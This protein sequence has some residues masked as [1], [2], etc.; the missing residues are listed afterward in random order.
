ERQRDTEGD[1]RQDDPRAQLIE[2]VDDRQSIVVSHR[3]YSTGHRVAPGFRLA[4]RLPAAR[5]FGLGGLLRLRRRRGRRGRRGGGLLLGRGR[6][7]GRSG[8][9]AGR[10]RLVGRR[11]LLVVVVLAGDRVLE[12]P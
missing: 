5:C 12:L 2:V 7:L 8:G 4:A 10:L 11:Q 6:L 1:E 9:L 3:P